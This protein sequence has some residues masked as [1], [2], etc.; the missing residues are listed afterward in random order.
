MLLV[1]CYFITFHISDEGM[2]S[3]IKSLDDSKSASADSLCCRLAVILCQICSSRSG[4]AGVCQ[5]FA[6]FVKKLRRYYENGDLIP[7][8]ANNTSPNIGCC[9]FEQKLQMI[10]CCITAKR[11]RMGSNDSSSRRMG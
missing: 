3:A 2:R 10:Q 4:V 11:H 8:I 5:L 6:A 9:L 1:Y 7:G